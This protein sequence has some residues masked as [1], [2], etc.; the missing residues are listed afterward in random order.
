VKAIFDK[1]LLIVDDTDCSGPSG[2]GRLRGPTAP[3]VAH[4]GRTRHVLLR[5]RR[6]ALEVLPDGHRV[7]SGHFPG[8]PFDTLGT[9]FLVNGTITLSQ[10]SRYKHVIW[11]TDSKAAAT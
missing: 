11:Y 4:L 3:G 6:Q 2:A 1:E 5:S 9:R 7:E 10:L 8:Y